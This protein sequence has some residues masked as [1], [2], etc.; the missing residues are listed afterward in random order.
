MFFGQKANDMNL[1]LRILIF[2]L[3]LASSYAAES[4][5]VDCIKAVTLTERK[6]FP[7]GWHKDK[8]ISN[9]S[10][11]KDDQALTIIYTETGFYGPR[12]RTVT[13]KLKTMSIISVTPKRRTR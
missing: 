5:D 7:V 1:K 3:P 12:K 11:V 10:C 8:N 13:Y 4:I 6:F 2:S 9:V